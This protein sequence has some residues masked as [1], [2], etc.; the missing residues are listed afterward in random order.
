[1]SGAWGGNYGYLNSSNPLLMDPGMQSAMARQQYAQALMSAGME[2][3]PVRS[4]WA[5]AARAVQGLLGGYEFSAAQNQLNDY[6]QGSRQAMAQLYAQQPMPT[7]PGVSGGAPPPMPGGGPG[8][9][10][11]GPTTTTPGPQGPTTIGS[12]G[13]GGPGGPGGPVPQGQAGARP[14]LQVDPASLLP[15]EQAL[16][17]VMQRESGGRNIWSSA[18]IPPGYT[19]DQTGFGYWQIIPST[20]RQGAQ[21][22]GIDLNKY[23][24][25]ASTANDPNAFEIQHAVVSALYDHRG[26]ADWQQSPATKG[27]MAAVANTGPGDSNYGALKAASDQAAQYGVSLAQQYR[28]M[29]INAA[30]SPY[31]AVRAMAPQFMQ[32][33]T[34]FLQYGRYT[35]AGM[36]AGG[37]M[38]MYDRMEG[39]VE[40]V[41]APLSLVTTPS[42]AMG[43]ST[44]QIV[45]QPGYTPL[46]GGPGGGGPVG[47]G[48]GGRGGPVPDSDGV[49]RPPG[50]ARPTGV[51]PGVAPAGGPGGAGGGGEGGGTAVFP[52]SNVPMARQNGV[53]T[54]NGN[55]YEGMP[56]EAQRKAM[57]EDATK[58]EAQASSTDAERDAARSELIALGRMQQIIAAHPGWFGTGPGPI[59]ERFVARTNN[60]PEYHEFENLVSQLIP[61]AR[62]GSGFARPTNKDVGIFERETPNLE[63]APDALGN[64]IQGRI[65]A[66]QLGIEGNLFQHEYVQA[67]RSLNGAPSA[68]AAYTN[69]NPIFVEDQQGH[70]VPNPNY[71]DRRSWFQANTDPQTGL[72]LSGSRARSGT[73]PGPGQSPTS[74]PATDSG[75][76]SV[77]AAKYPG[78]TAHGSNGLTFKSNGRIWVQQP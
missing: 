54:Y 35:P 76:P 52:G 18:P 32:Q 41:G 50:V 45:Y 74:V 5:A 59:Y 72:L 53:P 34:Q 36:T 71:Q 37:Q 13:G 38:L 9:P 75:A 22:A 15:K 47:G 55:P 3:T 77:D 31:A 73:Q 69:A 62:L 6:A 2:S 28:Q 21:W 48:P 10:S 78:F 12:S 40:A 44:G 16:A 51:T 24:T 67:N 63:M 64:V 58:A 14:P 60:V 20:W 33:S 29:A 26:L 46:G 1:M 70:F 56:A 8:G 23:P 42:G 11:V 7:L 19:R 4:P 57:L 65:R 27:A 25:P 66:A 39:K 61:A 30:Q 43:T 49:I 17:A 68:W